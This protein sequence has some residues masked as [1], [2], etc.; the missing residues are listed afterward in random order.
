M[1]E[2]NHELHSAIKKVGDVSCHL[3]L[4]MLLITSYDLNIFFFLLEFQQGKYVVEQVAS[5]S[6]VL[7][8]GGSSREPVQFNLWFNLV[9][10]IKNEQKF[11]SVFTRIRFSS[12]VSQPFRGS[13]FLIPTHCHDWCRRNVA[14]GIDNEE[15]E[16]TWWPK[17][18]RKSKSQS[19]LRT[20]TLTVQ[21]YFANRQYEIAIV[22]NE[23][24]ILP[25]SKAIPQ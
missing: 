20:P 5:L 3:F 9:K 6:T 24:L 1:G 2:K 22:D 15:D 7:S 11:F 19:K 25:S 14:T 18:W 12:M 17:V 13:R 23:P 8:K 10:L 16:G 4:S 21:Y